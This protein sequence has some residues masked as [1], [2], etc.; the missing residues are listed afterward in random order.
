[1][2]YIGYDIGVPKTAPQYYSS[3]EK[4]YQALM[5]VLPLG[6]ACNHLA[7]YHAHQHCT[8]H[9]AHYQDA[10]KQLMTR[11]HTFDIQ[12]AA[13]HGGLGNKSI[14]DTLACLTTNEKQNLV[15]YLTKMD[16]I[17]SKDI[18]QKI[19]TVGFNLTSQWIFGAIRHYAVQKFVEN[20]SFLTT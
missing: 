4:C 5:D 11:L 19:K 8:P 17:V 6:T 12:M 14:N 15:S 1:M 18:K 10:L 7:R 16:H 3:F 9:L 2:R 20:E 13:E